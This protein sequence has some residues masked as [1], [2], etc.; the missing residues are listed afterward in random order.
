MEFNFKNAKFKIFVTMTLSS[1]SNVTSNIFSPNNFSQS[2]SHDPTSHSLNINSSS[3]NASNLVSQ[4][5]FNPDS[6]FD[7]QSAPNSETQNLN[8][9]LLTHSNSISSMN[10]MPSMSMPLSASISSTPP[11]SIPGHLQA[12]QKLENS[13]NFSQM[14]SDSSGNSSLP[15]FLNLSILS[16]SYSTPFGPLFISRKLPLLVQFSGIPSHQVIVATIQVYAC[17]VVDNIDH[18]ANNFRQINEYSNNLNNLDDGRNFGLRYRLENDFPASSSGI[19]FKEQG[20]SQPS[21]YSS[22]SLQQHAMDGINGQSFGSIHGTSF[23]NFH[24]ELQQQTI[25]TLRNGIGNSQGFPNNT[26]SNN[27]N[28]INNKSPNNNKKNTTAQILPS[29][30][31]LLPLHLQPESRKYDFT[32]KTSSFINGKTIVEIV[33]P[34][35]WNTTN[36]ILQIW[37]GLYRR[38]PHESSKADLIVDNVSQKFLMVNG[39]GKFDDILLREKGSVIQG[40]LINFEEKNSK[41]S[42]NSNLGVI[43]QSGPSVE[44]GM[45]KSLIEQQSLLLS[46]IQSLSGQIR[47]LEQKFLETENRIDRRLELTTLQVESATEQALRRMKIDFENRLETSLSVDR[48]NSS[49]LSDSMNLLNKSEN[50]DLAE[51]SQEN[52]E[53]WMN[54]IIGP[55]QIIES[56][57]ELKPL[58]D[59]H[60]SSSSM[61]IRIIESEFDK[62]QRFNHP[63]LM[64]CFDNL[65]RNEYINGDSSPNSLLQY[66]LR[67]QNSILES[68]ETVIKPMEF[69]EFSPNSVFITQNLAPNPPSE[70]R[71]RILTANKDPV[72]PRDGF[73]HLQPKGKYRL[74]VENGLSESIYYSLL[75]WDH[76]HVIHVVGNKIS[77]LKGSKLKKYNLN[78]FQS[79]IA[80]RYKLLYTREKPPCSSDK[81]YCDTLSIWVEPELMR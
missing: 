33:I 39:D 35:E 7:S 60:A 34:E 13:L 53:D 80:E 45:M 3:N 32:W 18:R 15:I 36:S 44:F 22:Y 63:L 29:T 38:N 50:L 46:H 69:S 17:S 8:R 16:N 43:G 10:S 59:R 42:Q 11:S 48:S 78:V 55:Q 62:M 49:V 40:P 51:K 73:F 52:K 37:C 27:S 9:H 12:Q 26:N 30:K 28:N 67:H 56:L 5:N 23:G 54:T 79:G 61:E 4:Y 64:N 76:K 74:Q 71:L 14:Q 47:N 25:N 81:W 72:V 70:V 31:Y 57:S 20:N 2:T 77:E 24:N 6:N 65:L 75:Y 66:L 58:L 21:S 41:L 1:T 68:E 19:Q